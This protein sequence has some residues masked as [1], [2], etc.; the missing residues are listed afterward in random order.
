MLPKRL[1]VEIDD[2]WQVVHIL[3]FGHIS[4]PA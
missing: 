2:Q 1:Y 3:T 4:P